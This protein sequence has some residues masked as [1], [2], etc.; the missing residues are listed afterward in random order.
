MALLHGSTGLAD[1]AE[2]LLPWWIQLSSQQV[3]ARWL[4][5]DAL[6]ETEAHIRDKG[7]YQLLKDAM[8]PAA[9]YQ[10][11]QDHCCNTAPQQPRRTFSA[12][13]P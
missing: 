2:A 5:Y 3:K 8:L 13:V 12:A 10:C 4:A 9:V 6:P 7:T 11:R 1:L